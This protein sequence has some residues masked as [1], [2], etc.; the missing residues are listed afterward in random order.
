VAALRAAISL[1]KLVD[2]FLV[3][4]SRDQTLLEITSIYI[5]QELKRIA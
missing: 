3:T 5:P 4:A 2:D 1:P